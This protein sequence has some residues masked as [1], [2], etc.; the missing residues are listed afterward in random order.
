MSD[1]V[2]TQQLRKTGVRDRNGRDIY[3][4]DLLKIHIPGGDFVY[5]VTLS[6]GCFRAHFPFIELFC[7]G[8]FVANRGH[9]ESGTWWCEVV[10]E[11][12]A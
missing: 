11:E 2:D 4:G 6:D 12:P 7:C 9:E 3:E 10:E 8:D 1:Q 5:P